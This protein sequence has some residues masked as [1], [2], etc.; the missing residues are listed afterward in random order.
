VGVSGPAA[1]EKLLAAAKSLGLL[2]RDYRASGVIDL[3]ARLVIEPA[4][5]REAR[6]TGTATAAKMVLPQGFTLR[7]AVLNLEKDSVS[8]KQFTTSFPE[9]QSE[10]SGSVQWALPCDVAPC[11]ARFNLHA[12]S[13]DLDAWNRALNPAFRTRNW[14][15]L[16]RFLGGKDATISPVSVLLLFRGTGKLSVDR[17]SIRKALLSNATA[18]VTWDHERLALA[19]ISAALLN[20]KVAGEVQVDFTSTPKAQGHIDLRDAELSSTASWLSV[21]WAKG[22]T[23]LSAEFSFAGSRASDILD[24]LKVQGDFAVKDGSLRQFSTNGDLGFHTWTGKA[25]Y[26]ERSLTVSDSTIVT[27]KDEL[28]LSGK[29]SKDFGL[30]LHVASANANYAIGGTLQAPQLTPAASVP[31]TASNPNNGQLTPQKRNQ[32]RR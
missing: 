15:Y 31:I 13:F 24:S 30:D 7:N 14:F 28:R 23:L 10:I 19:N 29:V 26:S 11:P 5:F 16:P 9:L 32:G 21:P 1:A 12:S 3:D 17:L 22:K 6:W 8:L 18:D 4:N 2:A 20:G 25:G 27:A